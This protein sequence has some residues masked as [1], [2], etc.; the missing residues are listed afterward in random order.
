ML[1]GRE[2]EVDVLSGAIAG[3]ASGHGSVVVVLGEAGVGKSRLTAAAAAMARSRGMTMLRGRAAASPTPVPY[4]PLAE[5]FLSLLRGSGPPDGPELA[6]L[7]PALSV[8]VPAWTRPGDEPPPESSVI[9]IGEAVLAL[10]RVVAGTSGVFML[11][12][13]LHWAD[14]GTLEL[15]DYVVDKLDG[16]GVTVVATARA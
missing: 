15:L 11:L 7:G 6:G 4:R 1:V 5:A 14:P 13:D 8:V 3:A 12:E 2:S 10:L 9:L 16:S